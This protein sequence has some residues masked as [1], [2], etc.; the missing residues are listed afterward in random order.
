MSHWKAQWQKTDM[1]PS[2]EIFW[3]S[4]TFGNVKKIHDSPNG[5]KPEFGGGANGEGFYVCPRRTDYMK[6]MAFRNRKE[7][8]PK[9][10]FILKILVEGF[11]EMNPYFVD[12]L[13]GTISA[14]Q[15]DFVGS[16]WDPA[17]IGPSEISKPEG[18][19]T[20]GKGRYDAYQGT[21][22]AT[23]GYDQANDKKEYRGG[24]KVKGWKAKDNRRM[25]A[26]ESLWNAAKANK[27]PE[28]GT[29]SK[30]MDLLIQSLGPRKAFLYSLEE[31]TFKKQTGPMI[32]VVGARKFYSDS[33]DDQLANWFDNDT[34]VELEEVEKLIA[35]VK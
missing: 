3:H 21:T 15:C 27:A 28:E 29:G 26:Q 7:G 33:P 5:I 35:A 10:M 11:Y 14:S 32:S 19:G 4:T 2:D 8:D 18:G 24:T 25:S 6:V 13:A 34:K 12:G 16:R 17:V 20:S 22:F 30:K 31:L 9:E 1:K 23:H